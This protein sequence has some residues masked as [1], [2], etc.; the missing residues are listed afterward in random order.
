MMIAPKTPAMTGAASRSHRQGVAGLGWRAVDELD[1][2]GGVFE[3]VRR[4]G[5]T[6]ELWD[7]LAS[8]HRLPYWGDAA[9]RQ[10]RTAM[11][12]DAFD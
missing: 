11:G 9:G 8:W 7:I 1:E 10:L 5:K 2:G 4:G 12:D 3:R 6:L